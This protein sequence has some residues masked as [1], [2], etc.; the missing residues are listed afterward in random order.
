VKSRRETTGSPNKAVHYDS[1]A[2]RQKFQRV[3]H[4]ISNFMLYIPGG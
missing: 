4:I 1:A 2:V 3:K